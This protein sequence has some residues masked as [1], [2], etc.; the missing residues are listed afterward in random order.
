MEAVSFLS[1]GRGLR[2]AQLADVAQGR[3]AGGFAIHATLERDGDSYR[4]RH[5]HGASAMQASGG[6]ASTAPTR[7]ARRTARSL[8]HHLADA[9]DGRAVHRAGLGPAALSR[10]H[11]AG[12]RPGA[13]PP[14]RRLR[15]G[16]AAKKPAAG[17]TGRQ[18]DRRMADGNGGAS[19]CARLGDHRRAP[20]TGR[21]ARRDHR[22]TAR[23]RR[24]VPDRDAGHRGRTGGSGAR[25]RGGRRDRG[26]ADRRTIATD[27]IATGRPDAR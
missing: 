18:P 16:D 26:A 9:G 12:D 13:W 20:G 1:P 10:P 22:R 23:G 11:G 21:A 4:H 24:S 8:P 15:K 6:F 2:R 25:R 27:A 14:R 5:R 17:R 19:R 3:H 7:K